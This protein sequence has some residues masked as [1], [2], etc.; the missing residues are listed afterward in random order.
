MMIRSSQLARRT[1]LRQKTPMRRA[2][3][4]PRRT[5][6]A[7]R[8]AL[9]LGTAPVHRRGESSVFRSLAHRQIVAS[10]PCIRCRRQMRSQAAHLNLA[11]LGK[12]K[13][14]KVSDAFL[15]PLCAPD[16]GAAGCHY[17]LDQ[18]GRI[19]REESAALQIRWLKLTRTTLQARGQWPALA[20]ADYQK[21][22]IPYIDRCTA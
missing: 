7:Q 19:P 1:P 3:P 14:L 2:E 8:V 9:E 16:L 21:I 12:G 18:S 6:L 20:E 11:A 4:A 10:L 5:G 22:V 17:L 15:V 13:G